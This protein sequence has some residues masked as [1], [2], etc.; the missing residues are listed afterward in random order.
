VRQVKKIIERDIKNEYSGVIERLTSA[1]GV[2]TAVLGHDL[3]EIQKDITRID[4]I[5]TFMEEISS[6]A[7]EGTPD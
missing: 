2:K 5:L 3:A 7:P 4:E 1:E 6:A